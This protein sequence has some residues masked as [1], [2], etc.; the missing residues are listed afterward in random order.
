MTT[1]TCAGCGGHNLEA[2]HISPYTAAIVATALIWAYAT[3]WFE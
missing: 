1:Y 2:T 3:G